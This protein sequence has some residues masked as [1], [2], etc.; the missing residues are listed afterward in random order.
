M[1]PSSL[2][3]LRS[4]NFTLVWSSALVSNVGTWVQTVALGTLITT[5]THSA[6]W[7]ALVMA[8]GF[9]PMGAF[10]PLGGVL[11]DRFDRRRFLIFMTVIE[12]FWAAVL[13]LVVGLHVDPSWLLVVLSFLGGASGALGFPAYQAMLPDLVEH[14]D[15]LAAVSLSSA[16]WN[17]G[18][19]L[20]PAVAGVILVV[21]SPAAAFGVNAVSFFATIIALSFV[22][23]NSPPR[24]HGSLQVF[25]RLRD[26]VREAMA[27]PAC[28]AA[29]LLIS[30]VA[31]IGSPFIGLI[32]AQAIE[33]LHSKVGGPA[34]L[35]TAQGVGAVL[36]ALTIA[37]LAKR[38]GQH[39]M[40]LGALGTFCV[41]LVLYGAAPILWVAAVAIALVGA[42]YVG[43]LSGL[44]SLVQM[45]A[46]E[47]ARARILSIFMMGLGVIYPIGMVIEGAI[48][49][50]I[51]VRWMT[52]LS[53]VILGVVLGGI[54][55]FSPGIFRSLSAPGGATVLDPGVPE[56]GEVD[57]ARGLLEE[58]PL[59]EG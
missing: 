16:Q 33:G 7:T 23:V 4:R 46:P 3:P 21:W 11:A 8:A 9:L 22:R 14:E 55:L 50:V 28:R 27:E 37:P 12:T 41:A 13:A 19:V 30:V 20:G 40:I 53:G 57:L 10:A 15:L 43:I 25:A 48:G 17:M 39:W 1:L 44:N 34:V 35:T 58:S 32:A 59:T 38:R 52:L 51:G 47:A 5:T 42:S 56:V 26:G 49:Q 2:H 54:A 29:I 36:G 18:R 6:L 24:T 31:L 45:R